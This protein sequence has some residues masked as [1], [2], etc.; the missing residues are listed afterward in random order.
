MSSITNTRIF[1]ILFAILALVTG[2]LQAG[3]SQQNPSS[4]SNNSSAEEASSGEEVLLDAEGVFIIALDYNAGTGYEWVC[5]VEPEG[6]FFIQS[7]DT[8][9]TE[10]SKEPI[11]GG[12]LRDYVTVR[13]AEPGKATL[14]CELIRPWEDSEPA[15]VQTFVFDVNKTLDMHFIAEESNYTTEPERAYNS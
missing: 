4:S 12:G 6:P 9:S 3:C 2:F 13:A 10:T 15:E 7:Q 11:S 8:E 5:R 1:V 14:T